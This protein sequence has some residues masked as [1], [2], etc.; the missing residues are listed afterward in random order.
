MSLYNT[1]FGKSGEEIATSFLIKSGY[2]IVERNF[3]KRYGEI[4]IIAIDSSNKKEPVLVFVEV[5][6]RTSSDYGVPLESI[7]PWKLRSVIK[8]VEYY[9]LTHKNLPE[10]LRIDAVSVDLS[11]GE[12]RIEHI[13]N[14]SGF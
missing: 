7:T 11:N 2:K 12:E 14:I 5:K 3:K 9:V 8:T 13:K 1:S 4:D 10:L 6:T